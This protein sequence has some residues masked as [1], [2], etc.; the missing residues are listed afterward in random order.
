ML[1]FEWKIQYKSIILYSAKAISPLWERL[2][3]AEKK[4]CM[5]ESKKPGF[6]LST[7]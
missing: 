6:D 1:L 3:N 7:K 2:W 4:K 5:K